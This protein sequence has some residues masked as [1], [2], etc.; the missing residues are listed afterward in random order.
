MGIGSVPYPPKKIDDYS[1]NVAADYTV[2]AFGDAAVM[3]DE[4]VALVISGKKRV[5]ASG[6]VVRSLNDVVRPMSPG[7]LRAHRLL[8]RCRKLA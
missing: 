8:D 1:G 7:V 4:H 6:K 3:A 2:V 5:T